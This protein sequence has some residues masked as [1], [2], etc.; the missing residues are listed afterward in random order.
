MPKILFFPVRSIPPYWK[1]Y[2]SSQTSK[3]SKSSQSK[4]RKTKA[5]IWGC[6][7]KEFLKIRTFTHFLFSLAYRYPRRYRQL[8]C[9]VTHRVT[10]S[11]VI[12]KGEGWNGSCKPSYMN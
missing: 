9:I 6:T 8:A 12:E 7:L 5:D 11:R 3:D 4:I 2:P 10:D 1:N